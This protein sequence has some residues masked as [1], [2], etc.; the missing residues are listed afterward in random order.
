[1]VCGEAEALRLES[2]EAQAAQAR[3]KLVDLMSGFELL[4]TLTVAG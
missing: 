3:G 2:D 4:K 1:M